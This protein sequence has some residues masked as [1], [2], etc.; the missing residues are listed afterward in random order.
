MREPGGGLRAV[1]MRR[2][3]MHPARTAVGWNGYKVKTL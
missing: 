2:T 1:A 3:S